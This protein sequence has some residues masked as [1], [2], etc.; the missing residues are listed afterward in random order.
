MKQSRRQWTG[1]CV[2]RE[3][4]ING[5]VISLGG[6]E[7]SP[8]IQRIFWAAMEGFIAVSVLLLGGKAALNTI[9]SAVIITGLPFSIFL[10]IM[11]I[12]LSKEI[13][14]SYRKHRHNKMIK[15]KRRLKKIKDD[16]D[17]R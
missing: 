2:S 6:K 1:F 12:S 7:D 15:F 5:G 17:Y 9:Q 14:L 16:A 13:K 10:L 11:M 3:E 8:K 4:T